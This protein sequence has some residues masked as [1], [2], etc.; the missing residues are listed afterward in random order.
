MVNVNVIKSYMAKVY[1][2]QE[3]PIFLEAKY[4]KTF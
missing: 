2:N 3:I 4:T 1:L